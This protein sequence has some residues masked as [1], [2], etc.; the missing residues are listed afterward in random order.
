MNRT[1]GLRPF[2]GSDLAAVVAWQNDALGVAQRLGRPFPVDEAAA[3]QWLAQATSREAFPTQVV[4][5]LTLDTTPHPIGLV[6]LREIHWLHRSGEVGVCIAEP[7]LQGQG[8]GGAALGQI[9]AYGFDRLGLERLWARVRA[10]NRAALALFAKAGFQR[11]G[12]L[13]RHVF[14]E[15]QRRD[16]V[17]LGLLA[18]ER[19]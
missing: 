17:L 8:L 16:V 12:V 11:E 15:G 6:Q 10:D 14:Q 4:F 1:V 3:Q 19:P 18:G 9:L 13:R 5:A 2:H 7:T